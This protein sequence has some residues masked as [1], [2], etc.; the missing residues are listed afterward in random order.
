M[1]RGTYE[2]HMNK[3]KTENRKCHLCNK[4]FRYGKVLVAHI[5]AKHKNMQDTVA[6]KNETET[7]IPNLTEESNAPTSSGNIC[8]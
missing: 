7:E 1:R 5:A 8:S 2:K 4:T 6:I 3:H